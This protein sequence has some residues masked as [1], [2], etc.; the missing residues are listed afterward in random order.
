[1][2][3][4]VVEERSKLWINYLTSVTNLMPIC[5]AVNSWKSSLQAYGIVAWTMLLSPPVSLSLQY[6]HLYSLFFRLA[7]A[8]K[9]HFLQ[10]WTLYISETSQSLSF[11]NLEAPRVNDQYTMGD[12]AITLHLSESQ[13][14]I[15]ASTFSRL[16]VQI[17]KFSS[18]S[19]MNLV[20]DHMSQSL[21]VS[22]SDEDLGFELL[23]SERIEH[24][25]NQTELTSLPCFW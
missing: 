17:L 4:F 1:M 23:T 13:A 19:G 20:V 3:H 10:M 21:V 9:P 6:S 7:M 14:S 25:L 5:M 11:K 15:S 22:R 12:H 2:K 24:D 16:L 18:S 8:M